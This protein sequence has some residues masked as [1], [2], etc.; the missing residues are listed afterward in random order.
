[1]VDT[2]NHEFQSAARDLTNAISEHLPVKSDGKRD[3]RDGI[4]AVIPF[5]L[6]AAGRSLGRP[7]T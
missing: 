3:I 5:R 4:L 7:P 6:L 2:G 1:M